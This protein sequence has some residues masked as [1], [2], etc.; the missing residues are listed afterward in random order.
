MSKA[1]RVYKAVA[2]LAKK[3]REAKGYSQAEL[4]E[5]LEYKNAQ[6]VSNI[7]RGLC[8]YPQKILPRLRAVLGITD[9]ELRNAYLDDCENTL[10]NFLVS[11]EIPS[12]FSDGFLS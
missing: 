5:L 1:K 12:R 2:S 7:E 9:Q 8:H 10:N 6:M 3:A 11:E 4:A